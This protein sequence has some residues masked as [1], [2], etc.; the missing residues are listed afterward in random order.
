MSNKNNKP[1]LSISLLASNRKDT[2]KK[3]LDSLKMIMDQVDSELVIVDTGCD[4]EMRALLQ[5]YTEHIIPFTWCNDFSKARNAGLKECCG[6]WFLYIDDDEWFENVD[7]IVTFFQSGEYKN[8]GQ[9]CYI[10]RNY[11]NL[12]GTRHKD[13][14]VSRMICLHKDTEFRSSIHEY[15]GPVTGNSKLIHSYVNHYGY[16]FKTVEEK[17]RHSKRNVTLLLDMIK[18]E[19]DNLRWW[20]QLAQEYA[21]I[22]EYSKLIDL[23]AE[24]LVYIKNHSTPYIDAQRGMF[25]AGKLK[26]ELATF[27]IEEAKED[28]EAAI[29]DK[30]NT[31][32]CYAMLYSQ[33]AEIYFRLK[34]YENAKKCAENYLALHESWMNKGDIDRRT[35]KEGSFFTR[36]AFDRETMIPVYSCLI[37]CNLKDGDISALKKYFDDLGWKEEELEV[38]PLICQNILDAFSSLDYDESF[39][40]MADIMI[41]RKEI[42]DSTVSYLKEKEKEENQKFDHLLKIFS[43]VESSH[44]YIWYMKLR[45]ADQENQMELL[46]E[47]YEKLFGCVIDIFHLDQS[48]WKIAKQRSIDLEPLFLKIPFEHWKQGVDRFCEKTSY[49][50]LIEIS[51]VV[52]ETK[53]T[54]NIRYD[55]FELKAKEAALVYGKGRESYKQLHSLLLEFCQSSLGFYR[56]IYQE[57]EFKGE[58]EFLPDSCKLAVKMNHILEKEEKLDSKEVIKAFESCLDIFPSLNTTIQTYIKLYGEREKARLNELLRQ[59]PLIQISELLNAMGEAIEYLKT[60]SDSELQEGVSLQRENVEKLLEEQLGC[61]VKERINSNALSDGDWLLEMYRI[62]DEL[63]HPFC[64]EN[65]L[66][67]EFL[68]FMEYVWKNSQD[69]LFEVMKEHL[70]RLKTSSENTYHGFVQYFSRFPLWGS[71]DPENGDWQTLELRA[72]VL[73]QRS[74][75]FLWLYKR[76]EDALSKRTLFAILKN[77]AV[78]DISDIT[79]VKSIFPD[80]YEPDIFP[81]NKGDIFVDVGAF[82]GDSIQSYVSMYGDHYQK[83]YAFEISEDSVVELKKNTTDYHDVTVIQKGVGAQKSVMYLSTNSS[84]SS[85]NRAESEEN[86]DLKTEIEIV[87]IDEE[88]EDTPT[89]IKMDIEGAEQGALLG[90]QKTI[91]QSHPKLAICTYHGYEDIWKVPFMIDCMYPKYKFYMRH[92]GGNLIPTEF[93]LLCKAD[94]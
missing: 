38:S 24:G 31:E 5:E 59:Q 22:Q 10:Q 51:N 65:K 93:V 16:I 25:Y 33:G 34:D 66:D 39:V 82:N 74:Y 62:L 83:I 41:N 55:Y 27:R 48:V 43:Q 35:M 53:K 92:Y 32:L 11:G 20:G 21:G 56:N 23:C 46:A 60:V 64:P 9:A 87:S 85:A 80:Y 70:I 71:F 94:E 88:L 4:E 26:A 58:M 17:Y 36:E 1:I 63:N 67:R 8:Y 19:K 6:E 73:K 91:V 50:K 89:F 68:G 57:G 84:S 86:G 14:W 3:C 69:Q 49:K 52:F 2:T 47:V 75:E 29:E 61:S 42:V 90:C 79:A 37:S 15:L 72:K 44:Y 30:R 18:T 28:F 76:L 40:H 77:W 12:Q 13:A 7:E 78:L 45:Y 54:S 81:T